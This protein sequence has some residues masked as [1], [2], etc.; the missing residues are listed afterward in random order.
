[1]RATIT[2][3]QFVLYAIVVCLLP[4]TSVAAA[5]DFDQDVA[6]ILSRR[7]LGCHNDQDR[8]GQLSLATVV[9]LKKLDY[10]SPGDPDNSYL[11]DVVSP[12]NGVAEMPKDADPLTA[13]ERDILRA[14]ISGGARWPDGKRLTAFQVTNRD[15]WSL[16]P[17]SRPEVPGLSHDRIR[18]PIDAFVLKQ[19]QARG[20]DFSEQADRRVLIRRLYFDLTGLPPEPHDVE[21]FVND[22]SPL[23][24]E[25]L[26]DRLLSSPRYG[27]RW[28][29]HWLDVVHYADTHG[30]DKDKLRPNAWPYRDYV[31]R[32]F[33]EDRPYSRFVRE[34]LA[35]DTLYPDTRDGITATGFMA[36]GPWDFIGHAEV[37]ETKIDGKVARNLDRDDMVATAIGSFTSLTVQCARCHNHKFDPI[38][39]KDYYGLQAIF[40]AIDRADRP[41]DSDPQ[42]AATRLRLNS[43]LS[44]SEQMLKEIE[45]QIDS[46]KTAEIRGLEE[47]IR[48]L[49]E[50][51][52]DDSAHIGKRGSAFGYHSRVS[53]QQGNEKWIQFDLG[54]VH[55]LDEIYLFGA[56]EYGWNDFGFPEHLRV[57]VSGMSD[58]KEAT[59]VFDSEIPIE[60]RPG[61][62]PFRI[63][64]E[65]SEARFVRVTAVKLWDR[66]RK[67]E[68]GSGDW[69]FALGEFQAVAAGT[70][71]PVT[72][73]SAKDSIEAPTRWAA[74]NAVDGLAGGW[75]LEGAIQSSAADS[76]TNGF[77][78]QF[79]KKSSDE[80]WVQVELDREMPLDQL[81]LTPALPTDWKDTPGFG[82]PLRFRV[83]T[84]D[85]P[86]FETPTLIVDRTDADVGNPGLRNVR[87][88]LKGIQARYLRW[89]ATKLWDRGDQNYLLA[90]AELQLLSQGRNVAADGQVTSKDSIESGRWSIAA[91]VDGHGSRL[92]S[93]SVAQHL[94][95]LSEQAGD[96]VLVEK[97]AAL[98]SLL[99][100]HISPELWQQ[101]SQL[102]AQRN[103]TS[104]SLKAL[105]Q[106]QMVYAGTVH[107]GSGAFRGRAGL[108]PREIHL[109][110][111]G[112]VARPGEA[113]EPAVLSLIEEASPQIHLKQETDESARRVALANW[114]VDSRHPLTWR[115]IANRIWQHHFGLGIVATPN[116]FGRM[117]QQPSH[118]ELLDYLASTIRDE[119]GSLKQLHRMIVM[120]HT[121]RQSS[122]IR[123]TAAQID[124]GNRSLCRMNRKRLEAEAI[125]DSVLSVSGAM[126]S[127]MYGPGFRDF[128]IE[129][130][131][132]SPH[133]EYEKH[134]PLD[135]STHRRAIYR[136]LV[137]SQQEPFME[138]LD[139]ADPSQRVA[140]RNETLTASQ[141]LTLM[142]N[143][144][145][146]GMCQKMAERL[147]REAGSTEGRVA[148]AV[149]LCLG[150]EPEPRELNALTKYA[151][152]YGLENLA[153]VLFNLNE[154]V[155][156]D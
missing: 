21:E 73:L 78:S 76:P 102:E 1:M 26:V 117:G 98:K 97:K 50:A 31:I 148:L 94:R 100:Q 82:F 85:D 139:C 120:S 54:R 135:A 22:Q 146:L 20:L 75:S 61:A 101:Q 119:G 66:R 4:A 129:K 36:A 25:R 128:V 23:A 30:Y 64:F 51:R 32:A 43:E 144:Y 103:K 122:A 108:G 56:A 84:A 70:V 40:A 71:I 14:W 2:H 83:E 154:F 52:Q 67:G 46:Q 114:L 99:S 42:V 132:H 49:S 19:L 125:R 155:F 59:S 6:P 141:A 115:S 33:N 93:T 39:Q 38:T 118:P 88:P 142:N 133:Y 47:S 10:L 8:K 130:P 16:K 15:W 3:C 48:K 121:Y 110:I 7:C 138:T 81:I 45:K 24:Y 35:G 131:Q 150:R 92:K 34:Q 156:V 17:V 153:R 105:P 18:T 96:E 87:I 74:N 11:L 62:F 104:A 72:G 79:T 41:F 124:R 113:V 77:H 140:R 29:R 151:E 112:D 89:T 106:P 134:D 65:R 136:F 152:S 44:E 111:R 126:R 57:E 109:L 123:A 5:P 60:R 68:Q 86:T 12:S 37:P 116:D 145:V 143:R 53:S 28:A 55:P 27:E 91:L 127:T 69:I 137:R 90:L 107:Q 58:F 9:D 149:Q 95:R 13:K 80:K 147:M 63:A